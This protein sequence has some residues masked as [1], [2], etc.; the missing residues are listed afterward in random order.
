MSASPSVR[1]YL[2]SGA[3]GFIGSRLLQHLLDEG[4][5]VFVVSRGKLEQRQ[6]TSTAGT[7]VSLEADG[8]WPEKL[9]GVTFDAIYH[10]AASG[11][12]DSDR[13]DIEDIVN[14]NLTLGL[15]MLECARAHPDN[16]RPAF[17]YCLSFWQFRRGTSEFAPNSLYAASKQAFVDLVEH[18]RQNEG[19]PAVGLLLFDTY[20]DNDQRRKLVPALAEHCRKV[21]AGAEIEPFPLTLGGQEAVFIHVADIITGFETARHLLSQ[22]ELSLPYYCLREEIVMSLREMIELAIEACGLTCDV[23]RWGARPYR[24]GEIMSLIKGPL[25]PEWKPKISFWEGFSRLVA[26]DD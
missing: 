10:L 18:Y 4:H 2:I 12:I 13:Y 14:A 20:G 16:S 17:I 26:G 25:L 6:K 5:R 24:N 8:T 3:T 22:R 21:K 9:N 7:L 15:K 11:G 1:N 19:I 23:I